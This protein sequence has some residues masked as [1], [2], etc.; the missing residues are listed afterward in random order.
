MA[1][2]LAVVGAQW[3]DEGKGKVVDLL[4][5]RFDV[6]ARYQGGPN[7]GHT[8]TIGGRRH[9]LRHIPSGVFRP[10]ARIVIGNGTVLDLAQLIQEIDGLLA[11]G[12]ALDRRLFISDRAHV[13]LPLM[14]RL[15]ALAEST[16]GEAAKIGTTQR[17]IGPTYEAKAARIG[18]RLA[19]LADLA[20]LTEKVRRLVLGAPGRR[21]REAGED[22]GSPE[23]I[24]AE[25]HAHGA[26]LAPYV[27]DT[28][29]LLNDWMDQ[30]LAIL[31]E[32]A[33]GTL[34][35]LDHGSYPFVTSSSTVAGGLCGGLGIA[36]TRVHAV[37][38]V[39]KAYCSRVGSGP[40]PTE[41]TDGPQGMGELLRSRGREFGTVTGRPRRTGWF[42]GVAAAYANRINRFDGICVMLLDVLDAFDEIPV[43]VGYRLDGETLRSI[44]PCVS[45]GARIEPVYER[46]PGWKTDTTGMSQWQ[47][48]PAAARAYL[49]RLA[50]I[51]GAEVALVSV[52]PDRTQSIVK[53]GSI[54]ARRLARS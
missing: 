45:D 28:T 30:G 53:P 2:N 20:L 46:L 47:D 52:G 44:P 34:L 4:S 9:A 7:A 27:A 24:A 11:G 18:L 49:D 25:A 26:R 5:E 36:P 54:I 22:P 29:L 43:C 14:A 23:T 21:L 3:G 41:L 39:Y 8:V 48:L 15:D 10:E 17:G 6:V 31:F 13:V 42:D 38:G 40:M 1:A 37:A 35:D 32:G 50:E 19:D 12:V 16:A 33:Q 51:V